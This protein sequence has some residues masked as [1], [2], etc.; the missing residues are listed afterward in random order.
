MPDNGPERKMP[1]LTFAGL[2]TG[3]DASFHDGE[4]LLPKRRVNGFFCGS[5]RRGCANLPDDAEACFSGSFAL[6]TAT[7]LG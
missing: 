4:L 6:G 7:A 2:R 5:R 1:A 3:Y